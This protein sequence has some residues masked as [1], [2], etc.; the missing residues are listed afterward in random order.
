MEKWWKNPAVSPE[1]IIDKPPGARI[2]VLKNEEILILLILNVI[3]GFYD[4]NGS[5]RLFLN[6]VLACIY[7][8]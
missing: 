8:F 2:P 6:E 3:Y 1:N 7:L 5:I 4:K